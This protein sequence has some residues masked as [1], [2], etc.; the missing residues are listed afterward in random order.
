M[1][2]RYKMVALAMLLFTGMSSIWAANSNDGNDNLL[3][4]FPTLHNNTIVFEAAGNLW[5]VS[6][7]GG[8]ASRL[9]NDP[10]YDMMPRFSPDGKTIAF[11]GQFEGNV[12]VYTIPAN[13]GKA[14]RLTYHSDV[15][16]KAPTRWGP[17]NMVVT[18]TPD[19]KDIVFLSRRNTWNSWFGQLFQISDKGGLPSQLPLPKGGVLSYSPDGSKIAY[20]R[21]FRN[22]RTW[23]RYKGGLAQDIWIYDLKTHKI[24]QLTHWKGTDTYPMWYKNTIYFASDRGSNQ[25]LNIWAYNT[26]TKTFRQVTHFKDYDVDWP[27]LGNNGI[28]FQNGGSLYVLDLP[29]E[30]LHKLSVT[31]PDDGTYTRSR[32]VNAAKMIRSFDL[33]PNGKRAL[34]GARGDL[35]TV[36]AKHGPTRDLTQ[37]SNAQEQYPAWSP[38]GKWIAYQTDASGE[39]NLAIRPSDGENS[40]TY[41]THFKSG[42]FYNPL[43]SPGSNKLAFSDND[44]VLWYVNIDGK[45]PVRIDQDPVNP[46]LDYSWSPDGQWI[47]YSKT[48]KSGIQQIYF[49][50]LK[51]NKTFK[52]SQGMNSD[53][54]PV[55]GPDGKYFYFVSAR[56]ENPT[57]SET[58]FNIATLKMDGIYV[59]TLQTTE[60][61]PFAPVSDEGTPVVNS[62]KKPEGSWKAGDSNPIKI[63]LNGLM[64]R[65]VPLPLAPND[66][67]NLQVRGEKVYYGTGPLQMI[68]GPLPGS[69][70]ASVKVFDMATKKDA[71]IVPDGVGAF[72]VSADGNTILYVRKGKFFLIPSHS[73]DGQGNEE[74]NTS[75][76]TM[77]IHPHA[78]WDEMYHQS[79]R[80]FRDFFYN[81]KM[82]GVNWEEV[83][84]KYAKLL[85]LMGAREDLN[86]LI[87]EMIGELDNSHCYV[88]GGDDDY[89]GSYNPIGVLGVDFG[90][91]RESGL[92]YFKKIYQGDNSRPD[93]ESPMTQPGNDIKAGDYLL[94]VNGHPLEA[95]INPYSLFVN[96]AGKQTTLTVADDAKGKNKR[97]VT[98]KP[99]DNSLDL[100]LHSWIK[101]KRDYVNKKSDG[102][103]GYIYLSDMEAV[104][105]NQFIRQFYPQISKEGLIIDDRFNGGGFI[106]QIVLERLRRILIG[107]ST[108]R[109]H[110][111]MRY[112]EQVLNGY[113]ATLMNHYSA[114]DGDMFPFYF[115][116]YGLGPLIGTRT[117]GGVRGYNRVWTLIDGGQLV[118]S[119]NSIYGLDSK[120]AIED[121]GVTPDIKVD[122][123]PGDVMAGKDKQ[124]DTAVE[125]IMKQIKE[126]P[127]VLPKPPAEIPAYPSGND[128]GGE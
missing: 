108:N 121:H 37:T 24:D 110:A 3:C 7:D 120:W 90:L 54:N 68:E 36:P 1:V 84:N 95:P 35:F 125:Y 6:R 28:V 46:I 30:Q 18:W 67:G 2:N 85:P 33:A 20:N 59:A 22:F 70:T 113:K 98:V 94:A 71:T 8:I 79:W 12:D 93:Y 11:T 119:Q 42:Y 92:Y 27:S 45:N 49:Y 105:M 40:Q 25:R 106:D 72:S 103:I 117:W 29:S 123:L 101:E 128:A 91:N 50:S 38:D 111:E 44:H 107:M 57:F 52:V 51:E 9:T 109:V 76:M 32:W 87:G 39:N 100:R 75:N 89:R 118:V 104:G 112:P 43:W 4:R 53:W 15:V 14:K 81:T 41:V 99:I 73:Q 62:N 77:E 23:K 48:N 17:D 34:F 74:L 88:W 83:G 10:G 102:K 31:V 86:Y 61:S 69:G 63:D 124:L 47:A 80:L 58:E 66:Y 64:Q 26:N 122:N 60:K 56:H 82:N 65:V 126:H 115:R 97:T 114:S 21:I 16:K 55:F 78:E 13:G 127:L 5:K 19:G 96:T 116:K